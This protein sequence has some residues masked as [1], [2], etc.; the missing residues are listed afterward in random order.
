MPTDANIAFRDSFD[1]IF[2]MSL[3]YARNSLLNDSY[4]YNS[5]LIVIFSNI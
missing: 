5:I 4:V 1:S 3:W 2:L